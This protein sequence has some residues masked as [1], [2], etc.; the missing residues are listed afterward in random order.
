MAAVNYGS[1]GSRSGPGARLRHPELGKAVPYGIYDVSAM[2]IRQCGHQRRPGEFSV[3][4][5]RRRR[6][7][8]GAPAI[9]TPGRY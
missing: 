6:Y 3:E 8:V 5:I 1:R 9:R 2:P 7:A 4:S